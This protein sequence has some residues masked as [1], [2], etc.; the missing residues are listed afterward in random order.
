MTP[1]ELTLRTLRGEKTGAVPAGVHGWGMYKFAFAGVISDHSQDKQAWKIHGKELA[2]IEEKFQETF[3][4]DFM[5]LAEA[6]FESKKEII[7]DPAHGRL[8][9]AVRKLESKK[10]IDEF[11]DKVYVSAR[12][13]GET[14]KFDHLR[15]LAQKYGDE[16]FIF[17]ETEGPVHD[18][19]DGDGIMGFE[20]G[21]SHVLDNPRMLW[22][23]L[24]SMYRRQLRYVEAV[25][26]HGAH[27]YAHSVSYFSADL[28]SPDVY[29]NHLVPIQK[30]FFKEVERMGL[31]PIMNFWGNVGPI[32]KY[33]K[34]TNIRGLLI[35]ESRKDYIL[36]VGQIKRDLGDEVALFGNVS[37]EHVLAKGS[38]EDVRREVISQ[39]KKAGLNGGF[40]SCCGAP[41]TFGT[42]PENVKTLIETA[43]NYRLA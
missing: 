2:E 4:P 38:V 21:M 17:L 16:L 42:P 39:I 3:K 8:L 36:D 32:A 18:L 23:L 5:H 43:R 31:V 6:F 20:R 11:L 1:K 37:A 40:L 22:Y 35:D 33:V 19:L 41:I 29:R 9:E 25:K 15:I 30:S 26:A 10:A 34:D 12:E 7:N 27:G 24:E 14:G 28:V 13:L